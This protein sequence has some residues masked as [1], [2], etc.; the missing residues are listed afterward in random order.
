ME[1]RIQYATTSDGVSI[2]FATMGEGALP[3]VW[4]PSLH[5]SLGWRIPRMRS[6]YERL[7]QDRLLVEYDGRG[8]GLSERN[9]SSFTLDELVLDLAAVVDH[10]K[11]ERFA[12]IAIL[13]AGPPA[14]P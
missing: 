1:P 10:L 5:S 4:V 2:A 8:R 14:T 13:N 12:L 6:G 3:A 11:L 9:V 7:S